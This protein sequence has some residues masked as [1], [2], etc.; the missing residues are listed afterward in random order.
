MAKPKIE[1]RRTNATNITS[2]FWLLIWF[3]RSTYGLSWA[4]TDWLAMYRYVIRFSLFDEK[5]P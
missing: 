5:R 1:T 3:Y 2:L 4:T